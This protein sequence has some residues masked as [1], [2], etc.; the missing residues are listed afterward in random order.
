MAIS[1]ISVM[2]MTASEKKV[3]ITEIQIEFD[4]CQARNEFFYRTQEAQKL[5][6]EMEIL[7]R[8][9]A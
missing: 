4:T 6:D 3:R 9:L 2:Q 7:L 1:K 5:R 8:S